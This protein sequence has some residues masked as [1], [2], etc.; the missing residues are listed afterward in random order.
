[1]TYNT[2]RCHQTGNIDN[3]CYDATTSEGLNYKFTPTLQ[4]LHVCKVDR[5]TDGNLF[6][7]KFHNNVTM[8]G[9]SCH[10]VIESEVY[11]NV[12]DNNFQST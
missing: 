1:M 8:F 11:N 10:M 7:T 2:D 4:D 5:Q 12:D 3:I 6:G 9:S